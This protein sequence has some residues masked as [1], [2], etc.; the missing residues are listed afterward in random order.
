VLT[1]RQPWC[2]A[3][4]HE[5]GAGPLNAK[6]IENRSSRLI[7]HGPVWLH[8]GAR[9]RWDTAG[10]DSPAVTQAWAE[11]IRRPEVAS[12]VTCGMDRV[13]YPG[14]PLV[15]FG[16]ITARA[17]VLGCHPAGR[18]EPGSAQCRRWGARGQFHIELGGVIPLAR[19][20]PCRGQ[21]GLWYPD[22]ETW[23]EQRPA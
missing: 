9:S 21:R 13:L 5:P 18:C 11:W 19:P 6:R 2:W 1:I 12:R 23:S 20:V 3:I 16:A 10:E 7:D 22:R 4:T 14:S 17:Q 8:A 15:D